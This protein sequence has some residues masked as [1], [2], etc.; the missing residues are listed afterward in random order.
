[1]NPK[2]I[3]ELMKAYPCVKVG[4]DRYRTTIARA[5][6]VKMPDEKGKFR[7]SLLFPEG[8]DLSVLSELAKSTAI[9][10]W[11]DKA[12]KMELKKPIKSQGRVNQNGDKM[13]DKYD[14]FVD[15][16]F[17]FDVSSKFAPVIKAANGVD[18][19]PLDG[20]VVYSGMWVRATVN[21]YPYDT[22]GNRGVSFGLQS[23]QKIAD[24]EKLSGG[25]GDTYEAVDTGDVVA[26]KANGA[27]KTG[28]AIADQW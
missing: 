10:K 19:L 3:A 4:E 12:L 21:C 16:A 9:A 5:A 27:A 13:S 11:Q 6:F 14:G 28:G 26:A 18:N 8:A 7:L 24:D 22:D 15:G 20:D 17:Y 23:L 25:E 1:M 2:K